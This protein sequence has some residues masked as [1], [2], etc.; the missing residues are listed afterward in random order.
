MD[1]LGAS[2]ENKP[3]IMTEGPP[4]CAAPGIGSLQLA[5]DERREETFRYGKNQQP[6]PPKVPVKRLYLF[7]KHVLFF[8]KLFQSLG[9]LRLESTK[10][11]FF[12]YFS[13]EHL[14]TF[15]VMVSM[16]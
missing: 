9:N 15:T 4:V 2:Q 7:N 3:L 6:L 8:L 13:L 11:V 14:Q 16:C 5:E 12:I 10:K 1:T